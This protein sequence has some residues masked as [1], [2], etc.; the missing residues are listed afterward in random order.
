M[1]WSSVEV[2]DASARWGGLDLA[3]VGDLFRL[4]EGERWD[5]E[6]EDSPLGGLRVLHGWVGPGGPGA[7]LRFVIRAPVDPRWCSVALRLRHRGRYVRSVAAELRDR[8]GDLTLRPPLPELIHGERVVHTVLPYA[9]LPPRLGPVTLEGWLLEDDEPVEE[10]IWPLSLPDPES[11]Q[12]DNPLTALCIACVSAHAA[13]RPKVGGP[14][15]VAGRAGPIAARLGDLFALDPLGRAVL[16]ALLED[17]EP[18]S[19]RS[20]AGRLRA[21]VHPAGHA[22]VLQLLNELAGRRPGAGE[23]EWVETLRVHLGDPQPVSRPAPVAADPHLALLGLPPGA[24]WGDVRAAYRIAAAAAHPDRA[25]AEEQ[26]TANE[27]MKQLNAAYAAL[28]ARLR[29]A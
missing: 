14:G 16:D 20:V 23:R 1:E 28:E 6:D 2:R 13:G 4:F 21:R 8:H 18:E 10:A 7:A 19:A 24:T 17:V 3:G 26:S 25:P 29:P 15:L 11:M 5:D 22:T 9:A 27:R 12:F